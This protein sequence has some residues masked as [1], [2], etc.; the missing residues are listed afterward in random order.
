MKFTI[1]CL[2]PQKGGQ[3]MDHCEFYVLLCTILFFT[4]KVFC[5]RYRFCKVSNNCYKQQ[6][7]LDLWK[8]VQIVQELKSILLPNIKATL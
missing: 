1:I 2:W 6:M 4:L 8:P 7:W 5:M 3:M